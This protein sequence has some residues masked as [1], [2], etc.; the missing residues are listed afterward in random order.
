MREAC[1]R[2]ARGNGTRRG[3]VR[4]VWKVCEVCER[5]VR[6]MCEVCVRCVRGVCEVCEACEV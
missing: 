6:G 2:C 1:G 5:Y 3:D 4:G